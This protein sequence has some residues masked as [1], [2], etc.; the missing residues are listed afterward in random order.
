M[1]YN[2]NFETKRPI[3]DI[4]VLDGANQDRKGGNPLG[5]NTTTLEPFF[6][7]FKPNFVIFNGILSVLRYCIKFQTFTLKGTNQ[8]CPGP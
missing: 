4:K 5:V 6:L 2:N 1:A 8:G 3:L 7:K